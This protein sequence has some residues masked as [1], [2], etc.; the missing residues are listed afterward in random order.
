[1]IWQEMKLTWTFNRIKTSSWSQFESPYFQKHC[2]FASQ[3]EGK[4]KTFVNN[5][6]CSYSLEVCS[7]DNT[8]VNR[9]IGVLVC[10]RLGVCVQPKPKY[11]QNRTEIEVSSSFAYIRLSVAVLCDSNSAVHSISSQTKVKEFQRSSV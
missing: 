3:N 9:V 11:K 1:M 4:Y 5:D 6:L 7:E 8:C 2:W 10:I